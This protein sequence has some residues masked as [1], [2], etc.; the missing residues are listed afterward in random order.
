MWLTIISD[1]EGVISNYI[2][3][4]SNVKAIQLEISKTVRESPELK[5]ALIKII[6][7]LQKEN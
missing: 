2:S 3:K 7:F 1:K 4:N 5:E 6:L